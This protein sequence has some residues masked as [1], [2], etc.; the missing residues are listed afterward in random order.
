MRKLKIVLSV[1]IL[2]A[3]VTTDIQAFAMSDGFST[4]S[5]SEEKQEEFLSNISV[6]LIDS[7]PTKRAIDCFDV[8][9]HGLVAIG[10][11]NSNQKTVCVYNNDGTF[12][13]GYIFN[14][15]GSFGIEWMEENIVIYFARGNMAMCITPSGQVKNVFRI[16]QTAENTS[17]WN[18]AIL[19]NKRV[20]QE[21]EYVLCNDLGIFNLFASTYSQLLVT[22]LSGKTTVIYDVNPHQL[23]ASILLGGAI[24]LFVGIVTTIVIKRIIVTRLR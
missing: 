12:Q 13:Y 11:S 23:S 8:S 17:Y 10:C 16:Q 19:S 24:L 21:N 5:V 1:L 20:S 3:S 4:E 7:E 14:C 18:Y 2:I 22:D 15:N 9:D 6:L